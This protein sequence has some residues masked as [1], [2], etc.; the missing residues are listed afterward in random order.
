MNSPKPPILALVEAMQRVGLSLSARRAVIFGLAVVVLFVCSIPLQGLV[1]VVFVFAASQNH[2]SLS[3]RMLYW[4][5]YAFFIGGILFIAY[6]SAMS[7]LLLTPGDKQQ[8]RPLEEPRV[9]LAKALRRIGATSIA[10]WLVWFAIITLSYVNIIL[11][12]GL[13]LGHLPE[14]LLHAVSGF[15]IWF[16]GA[17]VVGLLSSWYVGR[18]K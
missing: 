17:A 15:P 1:T 13:K 4:V 11:R 3:T 9:R 16:L 6:R 5:G 10:L 12:H 2:W 14:I 8:E 18:G 7:D